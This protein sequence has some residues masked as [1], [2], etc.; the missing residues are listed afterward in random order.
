MQ[1]DPSQRDRDKSRRGDRPSRFSDGGKKDRSRERKSKDNRIYVSNIPYDYRWS[2]VKDLFRDKVGDVAYVELF[3]D[4][5][6]KPRGCGIVEFTNPESVKN[7]MEVMHRFS[8]QGRKLV[9]KE[10]FGDERDKFGH[11]V[12]SGNKDNSERNDRMKRTERSREIINFESDDQFDTFGLSIHFLDSIGVRGPLINKVFIANLDY[13]V[14]KN[15]LKEVFKMA[16]KV[17]NIDLSTDK[18]GNSRGFAVIEFDHPVEAVQAISMFDKQFLF[19]RKL[20]V[21]MDRATTDKVDL[22]LP[23][24]LKGIGNGL[25]PNGEPLR[26]VARS[27]PQNAINNNIGIGSGIIG[28]LPT[29]TL[30]LNNMNNPVLANAAIAAGP[31]AG[32]LGLQ[33]LGFNNLGSLQNQLIQQAS[34]ELAL[35][36]NSGLGNSN[37]GIPGGLVGNGNMSAFARP[38]AISS[39]NF[40]QSNM[41]SNNRSQVPSVFGS[42]QSM[43]MGT[44]SSRNLNMFGNNHR[45]P[46]MM[47]SSGQNK[48]MDTV[49]ISNL[50]TTTTW[51]LLRD[52]FA[53]AGEIKY[54]EKT[55]KETALIKFQSE[56]GANSAIKL[57]D[58]TRIDGRTIN[59]CY[60]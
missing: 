8:I 29:S 59:V 24:G 25:G 13:K 34:S 41:G 45:E 58:R 4:E 11:V 22:R 48:T 15:K 28:A 3:N 17:R 1:E 56:W 26:D 30:S 60:Y 57:F 36:G 21:R 53:D 2:E 32:N 47:Q 16:G 46:N 12:K 6:D 9:I 55:G 19:D 38:S 49:H 10:D 35:G 40:P 37:M 5:N 50:P 27:L 18:D 54:A 31:L 33:A 43:D 39:S 23:D 7:A 42:Q 52:K 51:Q 14:D 20:T 44:G